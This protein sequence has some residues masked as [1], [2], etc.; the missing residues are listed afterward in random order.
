MLEVLQVIIFIVIAL[1]I[2]GVFL[3]IFIALMSED[4]CFSR[5]FVTLFALLLLFV[6]FVGLSAVIHTISIKVR[7][8]SQEYI[9]V[10]GIVTSM[11]YQAEHTTYAAVHN[12]KNAVPIR[13]NHPPKYLVTITYESL[14]HTYDNEWLYN[15]VNQWDSVPMILCNS[16]DKDNNLIHQELSLPN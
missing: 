16:Y 15:S 1:V 11:E 14:S 5:C 13:Q 3:G 4:G 12:G 6:F 10:T 8:T 9:E 7:T 2:T